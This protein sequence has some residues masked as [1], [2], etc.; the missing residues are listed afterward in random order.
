VDA[1][2]AWQPAATQ[3]CLPDC[4]IADTSCYTLA[5]PAGALG[6][7]CPQE[8]A[9]CQAATQNL[10]VL[11]DSGVLESPQQALC[12]ACN[13]QGCVWQ[14]GECKPEC[15]FGPLGDFLAPCANIFAQCE[16]IDA[17]AEAAAAPEPA[18]PV[19]S[20]GKNAGRRALRQ[21]EEDPELCICTMQYDPVCGVDGVTYGNL[22][23]AECVEV[24]VAHVGECVDAPQPAPEIGLP[25]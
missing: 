14:Q 11:V 8:L 25:E 2:C 20:S 4:L 10:E 19:V 23:S 18:P 3:S 17:G 12:E 15:A 6:F 1:G 16:G 5:A 13:M 22:C 7:R 24:P 21:T 9:A